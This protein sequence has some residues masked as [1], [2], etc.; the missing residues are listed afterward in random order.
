MVHVPTIVNSRAKP[1]ASFSSVGEL[2]AWF[3]NRPAEF[4]SSFNPLVDDRFGICHGFGIRLAIRHASRQLTRT[5]QVSACAAL[6]L[7]ILHRFPL[8]RFRHFDDEAVVL[9]APINDQLVM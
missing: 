7:S 5:S 9:F 1:R 6:R 8:A 2:S 4:A 3:R